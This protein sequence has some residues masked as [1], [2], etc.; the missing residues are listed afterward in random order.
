LA[1]HNAALAKVTDDLFGDTLQAAMRKVPAHSN[2]DNSL[3]PEFG[4]EQSM[5]NVLVK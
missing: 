4:L 2:D 1:L 5:V 3:E